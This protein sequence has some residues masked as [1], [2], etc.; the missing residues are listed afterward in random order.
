M[1][2]QV[3]CFMLKMQYQEY[4]FLD[5]HAG[6]DLAVGYQG[7][8]GILAVNFGAALT[9]MFRVVMFSYGTMSGR[10]RGL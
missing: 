4:K 5:V 3:S 2:N 7:L 10:M 6:I 1:M 8:K 9:S